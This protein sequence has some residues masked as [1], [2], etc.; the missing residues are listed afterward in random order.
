LE[1]KNLFFVENFSD[2]EK[3]LCKK[4][5]SNKI[6]MNDY[7]FIKSSN[8]IEISRNFQLKGGMM[9]D[10]FF[11]YD[12]K[13]EQWKQDLF[14]NLFYDWSEQIIIANDQSFIAQTIDIP[15]EPQRMN[16]NDIIMDNSFVLH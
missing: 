5:Y 11:N 4:N 14:G 12:I 13:D 2:E 6:I 16:L 9:I 3:K 15:D 8:R 7:K 10:Q 1:R